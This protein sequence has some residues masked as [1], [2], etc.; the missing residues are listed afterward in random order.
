MNRTRIQSEIDRLQA[1]IARLKPLVN[2][3]DEL[4]SSFSHGVGNMTPAQARR[5]QAI[6]ERQHRQFSEYQK[7]VKDLAFWQARLQ[8]IDAGLV[9]DNGQPRKDSPDR[10]R[11]QQV[12]DLR[13]A[14]LRATLTTGASVRLV[15]AAG[16][17]IMRVVRC[18]PK[19][20]RLDNSREPWTYND[21]LPLRPD[22]GDYTTA[23]LVTAMKT[24][25][26][27]QGLAL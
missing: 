10:Q 22:G 25:L 16:E 12:A 3:P 20:V 5:R 6:H 8:A 23:E 13:A 18:N 26:D 4:G 11:R 1:K 9:H 7:A 2:Q 17:P 27:Q 21:I 19:S 14:W 24:W 15:A